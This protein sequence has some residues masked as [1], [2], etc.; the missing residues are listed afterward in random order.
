MLWLMKQVIMALLNFSGSL[1]TKLVSLKTELYIARPA[2]II[3][4]LI[5]VLFILISMH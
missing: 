1:A 2:L 4:L 3:L 5:L